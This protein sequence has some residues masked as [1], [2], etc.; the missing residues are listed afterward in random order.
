M[1]RD[2][3]LGTVGS[4]A[5]TDPVDQV[6]LGVGEVMA[7]CSIY[8]EQG[9]SCGIEIGLVPSSLYR[10]SR[11]LCCRNTCYTMTFGI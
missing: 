5:V 4:N 1:G 11:F 2:I 6:P 9:I 3:S 7:G 8:R 10:S